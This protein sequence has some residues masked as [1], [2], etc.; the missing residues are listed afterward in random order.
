MKRTCLFTA[1]VL[2]V[3]FRVSVRAGN[4]AGTRWQRGDIQL[5]TTSALSGEISYNWL[6]ETVLFRQPNGQIR[7]LSAQQVRQFSWFDHSQHKQRA[8]ISLASAVGKGRQKHGFYE[9]CL[10]GSL[11]VVRRLRK[12]HGLFKRTFSYPSNFSDT[13]TLAQNTDQ[14]D[15]YVYDEGELRPFDHFYADIYLPL[16]KTYDEQLQRYQLVHNINERTILG[17]LVLINQYNLL[18]QQDQ[19]TASIREPDTRPQ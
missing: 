12:P 5:W 4:L 14:F 13:Q 3:L 7:A 15:Y 16:M 10:D 9:R 1:L 8:F 19:E 17:R 6:T 2:I 18:V 11:T